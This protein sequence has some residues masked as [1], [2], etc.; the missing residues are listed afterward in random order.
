MDRSFRYG[1]APAQENRPF[2]EDPRGERPAT[3]EVRSL[4]EYAH[5]G[6]FPRARKSADDLHGERPV[7]ISETARPL[8][9]GARDGIRARCSISAAVDGNV[10]AGPLS[11]GCAAGLALAT[12]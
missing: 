8:V 5:P 6:G 3:G 2:R 9:A 4:P 7:G 12:A 1:K 11:A 10:R